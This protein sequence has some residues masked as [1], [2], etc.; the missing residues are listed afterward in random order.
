MDEDKERERPSED[1]PSGPGGTWWLGVE[2][3][4]ESRRD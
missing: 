4:A 3:G 1:S 2:Q